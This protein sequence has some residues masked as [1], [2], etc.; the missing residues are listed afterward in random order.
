MTPDRSLFCA[1]MAVALVAAPSAGLALQPLDAFVASARQRNPDA[2]QARATLELERAQADLARGRVLPQIALVGTYTRNQYSA[3]FT[4]PGTPATTFTITPADQLNGTATLNVPLVN[5]AN[6]QRIASAKT[7]AEG[8]E[9]QLEATGLQVEGQVV[10][11]YYQLVANTAL[12]AASTRALQ[13]SRD[14]LR[15]TEVRFEAGTTASLDVD[16][17]K[18]DVETQVEQLASSELQVAL[19]ARALESASA[20]APDL[21]STPPLADDLHPEPAL[22][23]FEASLSNLPA[24]ASATLATRAAEQ[25][26]EAERFTL[27]PSLAA[28][29]TESVTNATGFTGHEGYYQLNVTLSWT[30]DLTNLASIRSQDASAS[31]ARAAEQRTRLSA[32]DAIHLEW[33]TVGADIARSRSARRAS[34]TAAHA[35]EQA[36]ERYEAGTAPLL[37][38]LQAQRDAFTAEVTRIQADADLENARV[39][40]RLAAGQSHLAGDGKELAQ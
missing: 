8:S 40:L 36:R 23:T 12:V 14:N 3:V 28:S 31:V 26:A 4:E 11:E 29:A 1:A 13:F 15:I 10:Q 9:R 20:L 16:R 18:T 25:Q 34:E 21:S 30:F 35:A 6:F 32:G 24:V 7:T 27:V 38:L 17:A 37:D 39:Q 2:A 5:L 33:N 22:S 19:A